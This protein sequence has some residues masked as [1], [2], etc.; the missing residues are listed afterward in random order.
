MRHDK[1]YKKWEYFLMCNRQTILSCADVLTITVFLNNYGFTY[2]FFLL[3]AVLF[4][5]AETQKTFDIIE[6]LNFLLVALTGFEPV[7][8][9]V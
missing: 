7:T 1:W 4:T 8:C 2:T 5:Y 3:E 6:G 9:R